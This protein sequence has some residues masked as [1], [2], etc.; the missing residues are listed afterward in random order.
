MNCTHM[1]LIIIYKN[2]ALSLNF[3]LIYLAISYNFFPTN[4][5]LEQYLKNRRRRSSAVS[6]PLFT[7]KDAVKLLREETSN[8]LHQGKKTSVFSSE[9]LW[10]PRDAASVAAEKRSTKSNLLDKRYSRC[11]IFM[12]H[13]FNVQLQFHWYR[14]SHFFIIIDQFFRSTRHKKNGIQCCSFILI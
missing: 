8:S 9:P 6:L 4:Q 7:G 3:W 5:N 12:N 2:W 13:F 14:K 10:E 11:F 1:C